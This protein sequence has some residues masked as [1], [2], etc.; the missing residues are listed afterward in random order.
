ML[1]ARWCSRRRIRGSRNGR[2]ATAG[3]IS[4]PCAR[5]SSPHSCSS[6]NVIYR[7]LF[8]N[9]RGS[10]N[11]A[12]RTSRCFDAFSV[13]DCATR[14]CLFVATLDVLHRAT[15]FLYLEHPTRFERGEIRA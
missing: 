5:Y 7:L 14:L 3:L 4:Q 1:E 13:Y 12:C 6:V 2:R 9:T 8:E 10:F 15:V 11:S